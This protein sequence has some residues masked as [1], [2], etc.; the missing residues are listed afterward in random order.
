VVDTRCASLVRVDPHVRS[1]IGNQL[2]KTLR[3]SNSALAEICANLDDT[4][5]SDQD[6]GIHDSRSRVEPSGPRER[7]A[8]TRA[9]RHSMAYADNVSCTPD[10]DP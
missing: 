8:E 5:A 2:V 4:I 9:V 10:A 6:A 7:V 1:S 3:R